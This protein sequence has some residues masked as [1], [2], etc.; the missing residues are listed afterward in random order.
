LIF[1]LQA[2]QRSDHVPPSEPR[3]RTPIS[4]TIRVAP[5]SMGT[6]NDIQMT[7]RVLV[8]TTLYPNAAQP[9]HG[10]FVENRLRHTVALGGVEPIVLAPVPY[11]PF[12]APRFGRYAAF[13]SVPT[14]EARYGIRVLHPRFAAIPS[15][16]ARVSPRLLFQ[17]ASR[18]V[19]RLRAQ[20]LAFDV[21]D[22]HYFYPDGVAAAM[23]ATALRCPLIITG[24]GS[25]LTLFPRHPWAK[26]Q[27]AWAASEACVVVTVCGALK[28]PLLEMGVP[29][30]RI[31][32]LRNGVDLEAFGPRPRPPI[33][34]ALGI[35][36]F[37]L[38][39]VGA[40][41]ERKAHH[42]AIEALAALP[43]CL[44]IIAGSG[45]LHGKLEALARRLQVSERVIMLGEVPH[46]DLVSLYNATDIF[47]L[48]S[49]REGW[50]NVL[51]EAMACGT[52]VVATNVGGTAEVVREPI[53]GRLIRERTAK[54]V[55]EA[56]QSLRADMP[57]RT[58][59]RRYAERFSWEGVARANKALL[60]DVARSA[61]S[62][63]DAVEVSRRARALIDSEN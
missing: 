58:E 47:V 29:E 60:F 5:L 48:T 12:K 15:I 32:V 35:D 52:P 54:A 14:E 50:A 3:R 26:R 56:I 6:E 23:L 63:A 18:A 37:C 17:A 2:V 40:L 19:T 7:V 44:L 57:Q 51:L 10:I 16:S 39:S 53:T 4:G 20:G 62:H 30:E 59:M 8:F 11:F 25:D 24:R 1:L 38:L 13:A 46:N 9:N 41:I 33:R 27:I 21:I 55:A 31:I 34:S 45:P 36:R 61:D 43:D 49:E 28:T 22:A 42:L